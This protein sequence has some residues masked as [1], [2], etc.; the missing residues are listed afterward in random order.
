MLKTENSVHLLCKNHVI[1]RAA[2]IY[3]RSRGGGS[4]FSNWMEMRL[5]KNQTVPL[6]TD[7]FRTPIY[8]GNLAE[9]LL[10]LAHSDFIG[11]LHLGGAN[12]IDRYNFGLQL[13]SL[14]GYNP[15]LL[16]PTSMYDFQPL[17][18]RPADVSFSIDKAKS[19]LTT[20][21]LSTEEGLL[22]MFESNK[23]F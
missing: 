18:P 22:R 5:R 8:A 14:G 7:Q 9:M 1:A 10:E 4:S 6:Y 3:G 15:G 13:C 21:M 17:A 12:R 19:V 23:S 20:K 16:Q 11:T 2:L